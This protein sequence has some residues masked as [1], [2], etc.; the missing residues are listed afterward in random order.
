MISLL[1]L[2]AT[3]GV[4]VLLAP[5]IAFLAL[6]WKQERVVFQPPRVYILSPDSS[7]ARLDY[8]ASDGQLLRAYLV[9][10]SQSAISLV[11]AFHGNA[12]IAEWL[13]PW[14]R[15]LH[16]HTGASVFLPEYRGYSGLLG[17]PTYMASQADAH[18]ALR[19]VEYELGVPRRQLVFFGHSLGSAVAAELAVAAPPAA[20]ILQSPFTSA[21]AMA[22]RMLVPPLP[23]LWDHVSRVHF[24]TAARVHE[25]SSPVFVAH[26]GYDLVVPV[27]MGHAVYQSARVRGQLLIVQ[28]AGHNNVPEIGQQAYWTWISAAVALAMARD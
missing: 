16:V 19:H 21:R 25:L 6:W 27:S 18:A 24:D 8:R 13:V 5:V 23:N 4:V 26:G 20:L 3:L 14:A 17:R 1:T 28:G 9:G 7:I 2:F 15:E 12:D 11:I 10:P 22:S